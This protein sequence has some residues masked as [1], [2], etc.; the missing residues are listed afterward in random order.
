MDKFLKFLQ[1][2]TKSDRNKILQIKYAIQNNDLKNIKSKKLIG[3]KNLYRI[4][5]KKIRIIFQKN[6]ENNKLINIGFRKDI[7]K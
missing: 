6:K 1:I 5:F 7:Y 2:L 4:R 3:F